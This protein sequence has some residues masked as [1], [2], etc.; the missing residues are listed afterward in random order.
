LNMGKPRHLKRAFTLKLASETPHEKVQQAVE[1]L[2]DLLKDHEGATPRRPPTVQFTEITEQ[3]LNLVVTYY[4]SPADGARFAAFNERVNF[5]ILRRF[6][7]AQI[8]LA[9]AS[10]TLHL[11]A[12]AKPRL[13]LTPDELKEAMQPSLHRPAI[14]VHDIKPR[15]MGA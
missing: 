4:Y 3:S 8:Q 10:Q 13:A 9:S 6:K 12:D 2:K 5:D 15:R 1:I 7:E 14:S 11:A